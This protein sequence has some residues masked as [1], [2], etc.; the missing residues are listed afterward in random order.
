MNGVS[1]IDRPLPFGRSEQSLQDVEIVVSDRVSELTGT[2]TAD[3]DKPVP[4]ASVVAFSTDRDRWYMTSRFMRRAI[5][6]ERGVFSLKGLPFGSYY[7]AALDRVPDEGGDA[8]QD[9]DFLATL[10]QRATTVTVRDGQS[11][12]LD[13]RIVTR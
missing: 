9:P 7:V 10:V 1:V 6:G 13:L 11:Q 4:G 12:T 3:R 5:A 8:S 2:V